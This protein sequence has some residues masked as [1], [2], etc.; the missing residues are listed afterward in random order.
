VVRNDPS[1]AGDRLIV[2]HDDPA[3]IEQRLVVVGHDP[4]RAGKRLSLHDLV[5]LLLESGLVF[6]A[7]LENAR[8]TPFPS[9][10]S[11]IY[12]IEFSCNENP[13]PRA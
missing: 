12:A 7:L 13:L 5:S 1:R 3:G 2:V 8:V 4:L 11:D 6:E 10:K 9:E